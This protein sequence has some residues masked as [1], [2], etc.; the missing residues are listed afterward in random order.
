MSVEQGREPVLIFPQL[1]PF[2]DKVRE[3]SWPLIRITLGGTLF[4]HG[5]NKLMGPGFTGVAKGMASRGFE[6]SEVVAAL[7]IFNE[8]VGAILI[9]LGLFTRPIAASIAIE[10]IFITFV[11]HWAN[12]YGW[13]NPRGG[14]EYPLLW[15]LCFFAVSL[16]GGGPYSLDR[17]IG[18]EV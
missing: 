11:A 10:F 2:Y 6:P 4:V 8:T 5:Y 18:K 7:V 13:S 1:A 17:K 3:L 14:W 9:M 12:G 15:G 16:R